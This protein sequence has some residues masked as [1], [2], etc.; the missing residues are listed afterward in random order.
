M[1]RTKTFAKPCYAAFQLGRHALAIDS[2][3]PGEQARLR[4]EV[5]RYRALATRT[6]LG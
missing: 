6:G 2:S 5:E 1:F 3:P 4:A